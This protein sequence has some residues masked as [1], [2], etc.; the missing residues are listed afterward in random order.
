ML[1]LHQ[2]MS[3]ILW[4][5]RDMVW[6]AHFLFRGIGGLLLGM[7]SLPNV[8]GRILQQSA[9]SAPVRSLRHQSMAIVLQQE[10]TLLEALE[11]LLRQQHMKQL[12][13]VSLDEVL[14]KRLR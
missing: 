14:S 1:K 6:Q 7:A 10:A 2:S 13:A 12:F 4:Q 9:I 3:Q 8:Q 5:R 11:N